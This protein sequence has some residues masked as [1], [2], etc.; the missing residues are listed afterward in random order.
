MRAA[1]R[2]K[3]ALSL[4][5]TSTH[6][7]APP[8][9][10]QGLRHPRHRRQDADPR[11]RPRGRPGPR[12]AGARARP[13]HVSRSAATA[14][15]PARSS[16]RRSRD[17]IRSAGANV[18]DLGMVATPMTYFAAHH[19]GTG[20]SVMVTGSHN[21]PDYN[22]LK[23]VVARRHARPATPSRRCA[24]A[25]RTADVAHRRRQLPRRTTSCRAYL[26]RIVGDVKLARPMKIAVD[27]GNGV[28]GAFAPTLYRRHGLR[29]RRAVLR[30]RRQLPQPPSR[31]V[32]AEE[33][34][35]PDPPRSRTGDC[36]LGLAF[37]G[38]GDRLGVVTQRRPHHLSRPPA[39]AVRRRRAV[40]RARRHR[41]LRRQVDA[42]PEAVDREARRRAAAVEDR[43]LAHQGEDEGDAARRSRAR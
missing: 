22:G 15:C 5:T 7:H 13:R 6:D 35:R 36:E 42:Q 34:R 11:R 28:A 4:R 9:N 31:P 43:P 37:D 18:I 21:P 8:R 26:D 27:C 17:G 23:M 25:S 3:L 39:D 29:G 24:R 33:P 16:P 40:A 41:H 10:L 20:C 30:R 14:A 38:D 1:N 2:E 19:L 12:H 32:A